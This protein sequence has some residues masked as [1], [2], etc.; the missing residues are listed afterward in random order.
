V[1]GAFAGIYFWFP[2][3]TGRMLDER[4]G[5]VN[6]WLM[7]VGTNTAFFPM[8]FLGYDGMP[9]RVATYPSSSGFATLNLISSIGGAIIFL[10]VLVF[11][12]NVLHAYLVCIPAGDDPWAGQTLEWATSSPPPV[13]NFDG[14]HPIPRILSHA[15]LFELRQLYQSQT[16][17]ASR[18]VQP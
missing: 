2:K 10:S 8:F 18:S 7:V 4:L 12:Y 15:P 17:V 6:F 13:Y 16:P 11:L 9:R 3:V 5:R 14:A 1:F